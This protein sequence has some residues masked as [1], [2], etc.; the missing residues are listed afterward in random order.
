M[1]MI[2]LLLTDNGKTRFSRQKKNVL[3][4]V[5]VGVRALRDWGLLQR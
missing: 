1:G 2:S 5:V 4:A 3:F